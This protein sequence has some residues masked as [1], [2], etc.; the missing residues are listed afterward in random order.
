MRYAFA[1]LASLAAVLITTSAQAEVTAQSGEGFVS[2]NV[3]TVP[4]DARQVWLKLIAPGEWWNQGHTFSGDSANL[5]LTPQGGGCFCETLP[6]PEEEDRARPG[7]AG[8]VQHMRVIYAEPDKAL[9]MRGGLGPLQS[10]PI[11]GV[12]TITLLENRNRT[13]TQVLFEYVVGGFM[14]FETEEIAK[15]VDAVMAQQLQGLAVSLGAKPP[16]ASTRT[17]PAAESET[18]EPADEAD[19]PETDS[20]SVEDAFGDLE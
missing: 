15:A 19:E 11:D 18:A 9:R 2:R 3:A 14:R 5:T 20:E 6:E 12:L 10:E 13:G 17:R 1:G 8:S 7:L 16:A 4:A